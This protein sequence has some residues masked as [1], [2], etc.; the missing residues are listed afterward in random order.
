MTKV[1]SDHFVTQGLVFRY[2]VLQRIFYM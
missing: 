2:H 1:T